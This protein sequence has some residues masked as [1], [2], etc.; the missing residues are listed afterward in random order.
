MLQLPLPLS[1]PACCIMIHLWMSGLCFASAVDVISI[2]T[3]ASKSCQCKTP[4]QKGT[5]FKLP[6]LCDVAHKVVLRGSDEVVWNS[7]TQSDFWVWGRV[8]STALTSV[9]DVKDPRR[10]VERSRLTVWA[11]FCGLCGL[12]SCLCF[13]TTPLRLLLDKV[14]NSV[15]NV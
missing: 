11:T 14:W 7:R 2:L 15:C 6:V 10:W 1:L 12:F 3:F 4:A 9:C 8:C 5:I 13:K